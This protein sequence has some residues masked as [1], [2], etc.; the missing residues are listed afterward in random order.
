LEAT[1]RRIISLKIELPNEKAKKCQM[2]DVLYVPKL[3]Y[4]L[5]S[6]SKATEAG[7]TINF[8]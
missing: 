7:K 3:T 6:I 5:L 8:F 1:G 2:L 4:N